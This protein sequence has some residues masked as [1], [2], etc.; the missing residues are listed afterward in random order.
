M[1]N[2]K[3]NRTTV[4]RAGSFDFSWFAE[5]PAGFL[6]WPPWCWLCVP[7]VQGSDHK[8]SGRLSAEQAIVQ[9]LHGHTTPS[10]YTVYS[11]TWAKCNRG[12]GPIVWC[13]DCLSCGRMLTSS[14]GGFRETVKS[15]WMGGGFTRAKKKHVKGTQ[16]SSCFQTRCCLT[17]CDPC[18][19]PNH[20]VLPL[21]VCCIENPGS[22]EHLSSPDITTISVC[23]Y[24]VFL[25]A[26]HIRVIA[27]TMKQD[28]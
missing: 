4:L 19:T 21:F 20:T 5:I 18:R 2:R 22:E 23:I 27:A 15:A 13:Q 1:I 11:A 6:L 28:Y 17:S 25:Q 8:V 24:S 14:P 12:P 10:L 9:Q 3:L 16:A 7:G 26:C